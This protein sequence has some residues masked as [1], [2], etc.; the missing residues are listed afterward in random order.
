MIFDETRRLGGGYEY[1]VVTRGEM[2]RIQYVVQFGTRRKL[3]DFLG[4]CRRLQ[5]CH[6]AA[7][8]VFEAMAKLFGFYTLMSLCPLDEIDSAEHLLV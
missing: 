2:S 3:V 5:F 6:M 4:T 7:G 1:Q 8:C